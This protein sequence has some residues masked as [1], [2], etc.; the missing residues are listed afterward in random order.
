MIRSEDHLSAGGSA[1]LAIPPYVC[2]ESPQGLR[3]VRAIERRVVAG[4]RSRL[5]LNVSQFGRPCR[6]QS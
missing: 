5:P 4:A 2:D 3:I 6:V 1:C